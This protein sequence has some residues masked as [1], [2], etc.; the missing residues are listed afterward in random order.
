MTN[1]DGECIERKP[2][3]LN[4]VSMRNTARTAAENSMAQSQMVFGNSNGFQF[5]PAFMQLPPWAMG[6]MVQPPAAPAI[7]ITVP[8]PHTQPPP[9][10]SDDAEIIYPTINEWAAYC[11]ANMK[12]ARLTRAGDIRGK[13]TQQ[14]YVEI[15]QLTSTCVSSA[16]ELAKA[17]DVGLG[18]A[19]LIIRWAD[20]DVEKVRAGLKLNSEA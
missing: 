19:E 12:R 11:D 1:P 9:S 10:G 13:L 16:T 18:T 15:T 4:I 2:D 17:I 8:N 3:R 14:G 20:E 6:M 7:G 5:P